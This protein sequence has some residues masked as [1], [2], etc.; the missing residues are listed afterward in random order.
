[1]FITVANKEKKDNDQGNVNPS[2]LSIPS[3]KNTESECISSTIF[4]IN[5]LCSM[6]K[7]N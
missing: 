2:T 6:N 4:F 7:M 3:T 5:N 1:M